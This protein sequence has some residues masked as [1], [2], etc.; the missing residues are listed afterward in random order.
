MVKN[1]EY[2]MVLFRPFGFLYGLVMRVRAW[3]YQKNIFQN[4]KINAHVI[5][6]GN[7]TMGGSGKTPVAIYLSKFLMKHNFRPAVVSR[8]YGG[9]ASYNSNVVSDGNNI[10]LNATES[11]D[12]PRLIAETVPGLVVITGKKRKNP[13]NHAINKFNCNIII[14]DDAFQHLGV[15]RDVNLVLFNAITPYD[16]MHVFP[17][18]YLREPMSALK[19]ADSFIITGSNQANQTSVN[20]LETQLS[21]TFPDKHVFINRYLPLYLID[22]NGDKYGLNHLLKP[23]FAFCGIASPTR[24][25]ESLDELSINTAGFQTFKDHE[26]YSAAAFKKIEHD[27]WSLGC[28]TLITTTKD[29]VKLKT[30]RTDLKLYALVM[31]VEFDKT[32]DQYILETLSQR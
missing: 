28:D 12:E 26:K 14:M 19:R 23:V 3:L 8:G 11:G 20:R 31:G 13:C 21:K 1:L 5:S 2:L 30:I 16:E 29:L 4:I 24:F 22:K 18:G 17:S 15:R 10:L 6:V 25:K 7:I 32:F 27:A 9:T